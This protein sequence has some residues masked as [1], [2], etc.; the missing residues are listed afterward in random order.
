MLHRYLIVLLLRYADWSRILKNIYTY[1][2]LVPSVA[3]VSPRAD[4]RSTTPA[5]CNRRLQSRL[6]VPRR[7]VHNTS[8]VSQ[9]P[10]FRTVHTDCFC[11]SPRRICPEYDSRITPAMVQAMQC[12]NTS[13]SAYFFAIPRP[14][15]HISS[16]A[17][18]REKVGIDILK[19]MRTSRVCVNM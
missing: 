17:V 10:A 11:P 12:R 3:S 4:K 7:T 14:L 6:R 13:L 8:R 2:F 1:L 9:H 19:W 5:T 16:N 15:K 18:F